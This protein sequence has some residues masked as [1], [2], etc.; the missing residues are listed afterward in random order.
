[1]V[2]DAPMADAPMGLETAL[3]AWECLIQRNRNSV[4]TDIN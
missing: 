2:A 4:A 3:C 1:M